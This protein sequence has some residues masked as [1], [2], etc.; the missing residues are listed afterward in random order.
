MNILVCY[1]IVPDEQDI[2]IN[3][4]HSISL[5]KAERII[6]QYDFNA[7]EAAMQIKESME[8][9]KVSVLTAGGAYVGDAKLKKTV[10]SRGPE[11]M[12]GVQDDRL[13]QVDSYALAEVLKAAID[14]IGAVDL[15]ICGEG[16]GDYYQQQM[17]NMLGQMLG[18]ATL[19]GVSS[20]EAS[21]DKLIVERNTELEVEEYE[22]SLPAVLSVTSDINLPRIASFKEIM[23]AG[24]KPSVIW[25]L[26]EL[27]VN[28]ESKICY[29]S[30]VAPEQADRKK[31]IIEGDSD[32]A[33]EEFYNYIRKSI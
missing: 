31:I 14:K 5:E 4:D 3:P 25:S 20:I 24:K 23:G 33:V 17:G 9:V 1:K 8:D 18:W 21:P 30:T 6:G 2:V 16:S 13:C 29:L 22:V 15:V 10:L 19:N 12:Y 28:P 27:G 26:E 11:A 32:E 7:V